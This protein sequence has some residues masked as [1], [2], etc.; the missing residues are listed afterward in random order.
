MPLPIGLPTVEN[1]ALI[2]RLDNG[3]NLALSNLPTGLHT[4]FG[5]NALLS[6]VDNARQP[7]YPRKDKTIC[8]HCGLKGHTAEKWYK[9]HQYPLGFRGKN[10]IVVV[11][12]QVSG[13]TTLP[14]NNHDSS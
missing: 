8:S 7:Q 9:L 13:P 5:S 11:A 3:Y 12:N 2:S 14:S 6:R 1:T 10:K 4:S